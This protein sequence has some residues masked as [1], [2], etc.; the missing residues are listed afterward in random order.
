MLFERAMADN[1]VFAMRVANIWIAWRF[2]VLLDIL[3]V[4]PAANLGLRTSTFGVE[5]RMRQEWCNLPPA[6]PGILKLRLDYRSVHAF[7]VLVRLHNMLYSGNINR[8][9]KSRMGGICSV[10]ERNMGNVY[11]IL[12]G[13]LAGKTLRGRR[14]CLLKNNIPI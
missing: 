6:R 12:V 4:L 7:T 14:R 8:V 3:C 1:H 9:I 11:K 10:Q 2:F 5:V 13:I